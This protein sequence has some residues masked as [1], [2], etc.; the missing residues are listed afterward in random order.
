MYK[1]ILLKK[2][3][4]KEKIYFWACDISKSSGEGILANSFLKTICN[5]IRM[6][7]L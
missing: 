5:I 2:M 4:K 3:Q 7:L 6:L 1:K